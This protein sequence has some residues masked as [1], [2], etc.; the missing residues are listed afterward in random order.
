[1]W[2]WKSS[3]GDSD[4]SR[5][6]NARVNT[7][8]DQPSDGKPSSLPRI[9]WI[10]LSAVIG[11]LLAALLVWKIGALMFWENDTYT[12]KKMQID[13]TGPT[14]TPAHVREYLGVGEG[15]NL[16]APNLKTLRDD[17]LKKTPIAKSAV[18]HRRLPDT[19]VVT[20]VERTPVARLGRIGSLAVDHEG[21][22]FSLRSGNR[23]YPSISGV[24]IESMKP[25]SHVDQSVMNAIEIIDVCTRTRIGEHVKLAS[26]DVSSK[27]YIDLYLSAG[28]R[29][30][31][32]WDEMNQPGPETRSRIEKKLTVLAAAIK[33]SEERG[34]RLVNLDLTFTDQ[35]VPGQE[36]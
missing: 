13:I 36:Y 33:A 17:F 3:K 10:P 18:F 19:L 5:S 26:L 15:T 4:K 31:I 34:R 27:E 21:N 25:G 6:G 8:R 1:M 28:E 20:V 30:K 16:F 23:D 11:L 14:I 7:R 35:Y 32:A 9:V 29:I 24:A 2:F 22:V 12:I